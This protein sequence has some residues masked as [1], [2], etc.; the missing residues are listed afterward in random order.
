M[1]AL[2][3][4]R[5]GSKGIPGKNIKEIA[6]KPLCQ[7]TIDAALQ[8][9]V[10][11]RVIIST[12]SREIADTVYDWN[13]AR[14]DVMARPPE[15]AEDD[16]PTEAVM[17]HVAETEQFDVMC[18]IQATSPLTT[19]YDLRAARAKFISWGC[20]SMVTVTKLNKFVWRPAE[21]DQIVE[22]INY[23]PTTRP[24]RQNIDH[25]YVESG[26]FYLT[27]RWVLDRLNSRLGGLICRYIIDPERAVD[28]DTL[29]DFKEAERCLYC[30]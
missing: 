11:D 2:I 6:G 24:M 7:W 29:D 5:G 21:Y 13:G 10:F 15:L 25:V 9:Q 28:I 17:K 18:L 3:P 19:A 26:N 12:D 22:P 1:L 23:T 14:V 16:T 20:D 27:R 4:L 8:S 30:T